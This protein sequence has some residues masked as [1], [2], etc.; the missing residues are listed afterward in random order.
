VV[1]FLSWRAE[2]VGCK[3]R[4]GTV[5]AVGRNIK[6]DAGSVLRL[7]TWFRS[8]SNWRYGLVI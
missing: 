7:D 2:V 8:R 3:V 4:F 5:M 1:G 6:L